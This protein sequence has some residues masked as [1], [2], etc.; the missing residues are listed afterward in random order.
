MI[1]LSVA[2]AAFGLASPLWV[3]SPQQLA[4]QAAPPSPSVLTAAVERRV[5]KQTVVLR[6]EIT[7]LQLFE[8]TPSPRGEGIAP[9]VT[10]VRK[11]QGDEVQAGEV[12]LEVAGR[13][14][15]ALPGKAPA[16]RDL[17][18]GAEGIDVAQLQRAL[19]ALGHSPG[20]A[21]GVF[22][23]ATEQAVDAYYSDLGYAVP[24]TGDEA[25]VEAAEAAVKQAKRR[26]EDARAAVSAAPPEE[27]GVPDPRIQASRDLDRAKEDLTEATKQLK[28]L[29]LRSGP[30]V[31][32][33]EI[34][35]LPDFPARLHE[36]KA[37]TGAQ[38]TP[39][40]VTLASGPPV[41]TALVSP[42][43][44][45]LLKPKMRVEITL[46]GKNP[47]QGTITSV[48]ELRQGESGGAPGHPVV[49]TPR[50]ELDGALVGQ[51]V[52]L[53]VEADSSGEQALA[54]P[55]SALFASPNG[56]VHV[57]KYLETGVEHRLRVSVEMSGDGY[58]AITTD[59]GE[60]DSGD[61]VVVGAGNVPADG[62]R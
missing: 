34:V 19:T 60:L 42:G 31:P 10:A 16:Y 44:R 24:T 15:V 62:G 27:P 23:L 53:T 25:A 32:L 36:L 40:A 57:V 3:K 6:G 58:V 5:V 21:N 8:A 11:Q 2:V 18:P 50:A 59:A 47:V 51:G 17:R 30:M 41:V 54:V 48:G 61:R 4:A 12:L 37:V 35:F 43:Q 28:D 29:E 33:S 56:D 20:K 46:P 52:R 1:A 26:A 38:V 14:L 9:V 39:P 55:I 13:P 22:G 7:S 45:E 49:V